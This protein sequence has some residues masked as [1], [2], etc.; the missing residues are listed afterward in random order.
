[1]TNLKK[2]KKCGKMSD[3]RISWSKLRSHIECKQ[4]GHLQ[5]SGKGA[6]LE[7]QRVFFP[8][9]VTDRV[10]RDWLADD[11]YNNPGLMPHM[12]ESVIARE[13]KNIEEEGK[14]LR[15]KDANDRD[16][17]LRE[18]QKAVTVI[19]PSLNNLVLPYDYDVDFSFKAPMQVQHPAG[20]METVVLNGFMDIIVRR[21]NNQWAVYD[22]KHTKD[23]DYWKKT[24]GQLSFYDLAVDIMFEAETFE[25][26]LL[27]PLC[28]E[29]ERMFHLDE[30]DRTILL[31]HVMQ[32]A[33]DIWNENFE[34]DAPISACY[35]C[36]VKHACSRFTPVNGR[37]RISLT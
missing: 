19:E 15:W 21:P 27:Q 20:H 26:G 33:D 29:S 10:V 22:V 1:M 25:V 34:P 14:Q 37:G 2:C 35:F 11:P 8:G 3:L 5:R 24:R 32:M 7:N 9:T 18:C 36:N 23:N 30:Q 12:V 13:Q 17:I 28:S 6:T 4:K 16:T 31:S